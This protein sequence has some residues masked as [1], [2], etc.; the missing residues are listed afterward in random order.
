M[1]DVKG[2]LVKITM[3]ITEHFTCTFPELNHFRINSSLYVSIG[4][5]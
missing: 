1:R 5:M 3:I 4:A 2:R